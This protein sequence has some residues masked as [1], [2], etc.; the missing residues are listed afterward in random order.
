MA[1]HEASLAPVGTVAQPTQRPPSEKYR[2]PTPLTVATLVPPQMAHR[3]VALAPAGTVAHPTLKP[4]PV[5]YHTPTPLPVAILV[6]QQ[7][8][9]GRPPTPVRTATQNLADDPK[10]SHPTRFT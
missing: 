8:W 7:M 10:R 1:H 4:P 9:H 2:F 5:K 3:K 6:P